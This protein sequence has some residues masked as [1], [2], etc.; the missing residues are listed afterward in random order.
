MAYRI[1]LE[2]AIRETRAEHWLLGDV[3]MTFQDE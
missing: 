1:L 2:A 3:L